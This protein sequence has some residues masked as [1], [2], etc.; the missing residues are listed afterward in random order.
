MSGS[1][2]VSDE[3]TQL[4]RDVCV[5]VCVCACVCVG[6][7]VSGGRGAGAGDDHEANMLIKIILNN[8]PYCMFFSCKFQ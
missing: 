6:A 7:G 2:N 1:L 4:F 8:F 5:C 3:I